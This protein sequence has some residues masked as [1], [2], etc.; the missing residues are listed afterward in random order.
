M[1]LYTPIAFTCAVLSCLASQVHTFNVPVISAAP[2]KRTITLLHLLPTQGNQL[3]AAATI[4]PYV[5]QPPRNDDHLRKVTADAALAA[6]RAIA[7]AIFSLPAS[8]LQREGMV[9]DCCENE[10]DVVYFPI[11]GFQYVRDKPDHC[12]ALPTISNPSCH[13]L[14]PIQEKESTYGWY[15]TACCLNWYNNDDSSY[16][17]PPPKKSAN[18]RLL[19]SP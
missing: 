18:S 17:S 12:R 9:D 7:L 3:A 5:E 19:V 4:F 11:I 1:G 16:A 10:G 8:L 15:S 13:I 14:T 2:V 6:A